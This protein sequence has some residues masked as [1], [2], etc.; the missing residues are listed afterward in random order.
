M[1]GGFPP[2]VGLGTQGTLLQQLALDEHAPPAWT[3]VA[4][5]QRGTPSESWWHVSWFS[6]L[7][8][9]QSHDALHDIVASLQMSP[10]GLQPI[11]LR[12]T[13]IVKGGVIWQV[14]GFVGS[15]GSPADPQQS[16]S[17]VQRSPTTWHP[18]AGWQMRAP[19]GP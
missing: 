13:P 16:E 15:P 7:P 6:Q 11:G 1:N 2:G 9:Q 19:V 3:H 4:G 17:F 14:T 5:E 8:L 12:Q 18:V 10:S